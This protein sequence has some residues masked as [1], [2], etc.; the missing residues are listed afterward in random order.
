MVC[1]WQKNWETWNRPKSNPSCSGIQLPLRDTSAQPSSSKWAEH[2]Q[3][4][5]MASAT[6]SNRGTRSEHS[7]APVLQRSF[8]GDDSFSTH[9][10]QKNGTDFVS[11]FSRTSHSSQTAASPTAPG[12][13]R[14][15]LRRAPRAR[16]LA[17]VQLRHCRSAHLGAAARGREDRWTHEAIQGQSWDI[18]SYQSQRNAKSHRKMKVRRSPWQHPLKSPFK[19]R[20]K[21]SHSQLPFH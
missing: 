6:A 20:A 5:F 8:A 4:R 15:R 17:R 13:D 2:L 12:T 16:C 7:P 21:L 19:R 9:S 14:A 11:T 10:W 18:C 1:C 3:P